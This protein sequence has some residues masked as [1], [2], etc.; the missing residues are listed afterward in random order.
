MNLIWSFEGLL[1]LRVLGVADR[2]VLVVADEGALVAVLVELP[3]SL[4]LRVAQVLLAVD[5]GLGERLVR[6]GG[7][8]SDRLDRL[9]RRRGSAGRL[10]RGR[11]GRRGRGRRSLLRLGGLLE[12]GGAEL[13]RRGRGGRGRRSGRGRGGRVGGRRP[14]GGDELRDEVIEG[15]L[16]LVDDALRRGQVLDTCRLLLREPLRVRDLDLSDVGRARLEEG[17]G[18]ALGSVRILLL[19]GGGLHL[20]LRGLD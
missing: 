1:V 9:L 5:L 4:R 18:L 20:G 8:R 2:L 17:G 10:R 15:R 3:Q 14:G 16:V 13:L 6:R 19:L 7:L 11:L 12:V